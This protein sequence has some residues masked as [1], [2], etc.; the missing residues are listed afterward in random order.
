MN[1]FKIVATISIVINFTLLFLLFIKF[2]NKENNIKDIPKLSQNEDLSNR[3]NFEKIFLEK[4]DSVYKN[5]FNRSF[6]DFPVQAYLLACTYYMIKKD[7]SIKQDIVMISSEIKGIY[8]K[9]PDIT[10]P[11]YSLAK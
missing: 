11:K 7:T 2:N 8:G 5:V 1:T 6:E 9:S 3:Y 4:N 10:F